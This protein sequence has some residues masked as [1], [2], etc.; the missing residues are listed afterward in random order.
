MADETKS[1]FSPFWVLVITLVIIAGV[2][3][4]VRD[5]LTTGEQ[6][7]QEPQPPSTEWTT[8]P[9]GGVKV[10]LP[11]TP[12]RAVEP[13]EEVEVDASSDDEAE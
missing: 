4:L 9:E 12:M 13:E 8:A 7:A 10:D 5:V 2:L 3:V 1:K 11:D 6:P